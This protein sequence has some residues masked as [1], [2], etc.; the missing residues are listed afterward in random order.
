[1]LE[2]KLQAKPGSPRPTNNYWSNCIQPP[3]SPGFAVSARKPIADTA[4]L[5]T[6]NAPLI[7]YRL[8][9]WI[10]RKVLDPI[11]GPDEGCG[12]FGAD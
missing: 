12:L 3:A 11:A 9:T 7:L 5:R 1:M 6:L 8:V 10:A 2:R 4:Q